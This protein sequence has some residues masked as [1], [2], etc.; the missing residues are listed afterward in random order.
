MA[1]PASCLRAP[2]RVIF[3]CG[4]GC[5][6]GLCC[7]DAVRQPSL[8]TRNTWTHTKYWGK[9]YNLSE[10]KKMSDTTLGFA[11]LLLQKYLGCLIN[12]SHCHGFS[13]LSGG[14]APGR[15]V[16]DLRGLVRQ[17]GSAPRTAARP[18]RA[19][20]AAVPRRSTDGESQ[21]FS[22][23]G[24]LKARTSCVIHEVPRCFASLY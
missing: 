24:A 22:G 1:S 9:T 10:R 13:R 3:C 11:E 21:Q 16:P 7:I 19:P 8:F 12:D 17:R 20:R 14:L 6:L 4:H 5:V 15:G 2:F 18:A 23:L